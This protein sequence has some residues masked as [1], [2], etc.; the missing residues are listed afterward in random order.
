MALKNMI[1]FATFIVTQCIAF[2]SQAS[3]HCLVGHRKFGGVLRRN[4]LRYH[5]A[6]CS[7]NAMVPENYIDEEKGPLVSTWRRGREGWARGPRALG[8]SVP[9]GPFVI[10]G[11]LWAAPAAARDSWGRLVSVEGQ[12]QLLRGS[13]TLPA[14]MRI[15]VEEGDVIWSGADGR[16]V[17]LLPDGTQLELAAHST[18][19]IKQV[20]PR[21]SRKATPVILHRI[22]IIVRFFLGEIRMRRMDSAGEF[23]IETPTATAATKASL[24]RFSPCGNSNNNHND[25]PWLHTY[26]ISPPRI[27]AGTVQMVH[28]G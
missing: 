4:H 27:E 18:I 10:C 6:V 21:R 7:R 3:L 17:I 11:L 23:E 1:Y 26:T 13:Q 25:A 14:T 2:L 22:R 8:A 16:A 28:Q 9:L 12:V 20:S 15:S 19:Q 5:H 24:F